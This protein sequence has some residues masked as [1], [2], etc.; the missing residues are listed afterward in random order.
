[1]LPAP[2]SRADG[3]VGTGGEVP[4]AD[5]V[6]SGGHCPFDFD[7]AEGRVTGDYGLAH[8]HATDAERG[9]SV[10]VGTHGSTGVRKGGAQ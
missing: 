8:H 9:G 1:M 3:E 5:A 2:V 10:I 7:L 6:A 4:N